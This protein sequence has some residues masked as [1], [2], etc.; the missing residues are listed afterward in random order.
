M[1]SSL[2]KPLMLILCLQAGDSRQTVTNTLIADAV[3]EKK[4]QLKD[5]L[6]KAKFV[7]ITVDIWTYQ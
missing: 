3:S 4:Q 7:A 1:F 5:A 2:F 6:R